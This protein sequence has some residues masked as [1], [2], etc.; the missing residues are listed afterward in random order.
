LT[1]A[2]SAAG[3]LLD[4]LD[5]VEEELTCTDELILDLIREE[6]RRTPSAPPGQALQATSAAARN[7]GMEY[8]STFNGVTSKSWSSPPG[9]NHHRQEHTRN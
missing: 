2:A 1:L 8:S 9:K 7:N 6:A 5:C 4:E 3:V